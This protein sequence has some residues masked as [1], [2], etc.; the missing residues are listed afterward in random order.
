VRVRLKGINRSVKRLADGTV[1]TFWYAWRGGPRLK[2]EPGTPEFVASYNAAVA[3]K[4]ALAPGTL[5]GILTEYQTSDDFAG[6]SLRDQTRKDYAWHIARIER[7]F[8]DF[9]LAALTDPRTRGVFLDWRDELGKQG[10]T[11]ADHTWAVLNIVVSWAL[12]RGKVPCNPFTKAKRLHHGTRADKIWTHEDEARFLTSAPKQMHLPFLMA[13]WTGQRQGD[14]LRM[15][16][17]AYNGRDIRLKQSKGGRGVV[18]PV[19][20]QLKAALDAESKV[21]DVHFILVNSLGQPWTAHAFRSAFIRA[22]KVAGIKGLTFHDLRGTAVTRLALAGCTEAEIIAI[23]GHGFNE[24][25]SILDAHYLHRDPQLAENAM[26]KLETRTNLQT[27]LQTGPLNLVARPEKVATRSAFRWRAPSSGCRTGSSASPQTCATFT[28]RTGAC[29]TASA[30]MSE[31]RACSMPTSWR[32][33]PSLACVVPCAP[34]VAS[35]STS[36]SGRPTIARPAPSPAAWRPLASRS[37]PSP[38]TR[39]RNGSAT[40]DP[41][42][43]AVRE[44]AQTCQARWRRLGARPPRA[45]CSPRRRARQAMTSPSHRHRRT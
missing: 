15:P 13:I 27:K 5:G 32:R 4:L 19:S 38:S 30:S 33:P 6:P 24:V 29:S 10:R 7:K 20:S 23:T 17:Y 22:G 45:Q 28:A 31:A 41:G 40:G 21:R 11:S 34:A 3:T 37:G 44:A 12:D 42:V 14:L 43:G 1:K 16:W 25:R 18:V 9:P 26:R 2:G 35:P 39:P 36:R 8:H